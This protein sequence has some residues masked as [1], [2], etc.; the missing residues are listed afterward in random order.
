MIYVNVKVQKGE[1]GFLSDILST[2]SPSAYSEHH[3][4]WAIL[5]SFEIEIVVL[6]CPLLPPTNN[7]LTFPVHLWSKLIY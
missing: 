5:L 1:A 7:A 2:C 3:V 6:N 4:W